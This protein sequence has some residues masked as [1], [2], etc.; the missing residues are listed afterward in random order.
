MYTHFQA[1]SRQ[2]FN[3]Q[4]SDFI[5]MIPQSPY[6]YFDKQKKNDNKKKL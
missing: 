4:N 2:K 5:K 6:P 1:N 3:F